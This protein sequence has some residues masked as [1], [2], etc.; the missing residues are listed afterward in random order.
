MTRLRSMNAPP[1]R[2]SSGE[3]LLYCTLPQPPAEDLAAG[4]AAFYLIP[5]A[6]ETR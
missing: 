4:C 6:D 3:T 5:S 1:G 2:A